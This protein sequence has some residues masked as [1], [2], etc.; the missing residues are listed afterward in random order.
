MDHT[1]DS[2]LLTSYY[3]EFLTQPNTNHCLIVIYSIVEYQYKFWHLS[4]LLITISIVNQNWK[5]GLTMV[6][7]IGEH[8]IQIAK[9]LVGMLSV[10][11]WDTNVNR[12]QMDHTFYLIFYTL[13]IY[14]EF[15]RWLHIYIKSCHKMEKLI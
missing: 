14:G 8:K 10:A 5:C 2:T 1:Y 13:Y 11:L 7:V 6:Y 12:P 3:E 15:Q 9:Q 4:F